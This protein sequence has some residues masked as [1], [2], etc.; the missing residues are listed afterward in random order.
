MRF[1]K[2][3]RFKLKNLRYLYRNR[4]Y[5]A[6]KIIIFNLLRYLARYYKSGDEGT[7]IFT[8]GIMTGID[9]DILET[10]VSDLII[11]KK[12]YECNVYEYRIC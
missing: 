7:T 3:F 1:L 5:E 6:I 8:L 10:I 2:R 9:V 12:I 4:F 11:E